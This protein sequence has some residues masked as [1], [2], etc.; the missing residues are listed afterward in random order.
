MAGVGFALRKLAAKDTLFHK[1][2]AYLHG[3]LLTA[4]PWLFTILALGL[5]A[6]F[7]RD[8]QTMEKVVEFRTLLTYNFAFSIVVTAPFCMLATRVLSDALY[9]G[10]TAVAGT[11]LVQVL[12]MSQLFLLLTGFLLYVVVA[13]LSLRMQ[14]SAMLNL[15][16]LG[17]IWVATIFLS[18]VRRFGITTLAFAIGLLIATVGTIIFLPHYD[19]V[20]GLVLFNVGLAVLLGILLGVIT[21]EYPLTQSAPLS[22]RKEARKHWALLLGAFLYNIALWADKWILWFAKDAH[23]LPNHLRVH[24]VY[25]TALF[26]AFLTVIPGMVFF[27]VHLETRFFEALRGYFRVISRKGSYAQVDQ[28]RADLIPIFARG[29]RNLMVFQGSI[30]IL[31]ALLAP[32]LFS[33]PRF[34]FL[35]LGVFRIAVLAAFFQTM[36]LCLATILS[37]VDDQKGYLY[38]QLLFLSVNIIAT[39]ITLKIGF[40]SYGYGFFL[41]TATVFTFYV[42]RVSHQLEHLTYRLLF[43]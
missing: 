34:D 35:Q 29:L 2:Q 4:G 24:S 18:A 15:Q 22:L 36:A 5:V 23:V 43:R 21:S 27:V 30:S 28:A 3:L 19:S 26:L 25:D 37:Y 31:A 1:G 38:G 14:L 17:C 33:L 8:V 20:T 32:Y 16:L 9:R 10:Q 39:L 40:A 12:W 42:W 13:E 7:A 6:T 41:A 11:L